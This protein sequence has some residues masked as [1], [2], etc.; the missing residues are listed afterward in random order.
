MTLIQG[1]KIVVLHKYLRLLF[2]FHNGKRVTSQRALEMLLPQKHNFSKGL[3][4][5]HKKSLEFY[6]KISQSLNSHRSLKTWH[7]S[8]NVIS[9]IVDVS[10]KQHMTHL[11]SLR[12]T[13]WWL[14]RCLT[15]TRHD[16]L[17]DFMMQMAKC[18]G[19]CHFWLKKKKRCKK[20]LC[21][22]KQ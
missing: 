6:D 21:L 2:P 16:T 5:F 11:E 19:G 8:W 3:T 20:H 7:P 10:V 18:W 15:L 22:Q 12:V 9:I 4:H 14:Q 1:W 13:W 17:K